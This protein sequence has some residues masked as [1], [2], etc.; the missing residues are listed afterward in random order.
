MPTHHR[1]ALAG[2]NDVGQSNKPETGGFVR[3]VGS[4]LDAVV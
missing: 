4:A 2:R 3:C 1:E